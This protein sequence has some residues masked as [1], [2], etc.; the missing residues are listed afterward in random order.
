[1]GNILSVICSPRGKPATSITATENILSVRWK[2]KGMLMTSMFKRI[3]Q[4]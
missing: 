4:Y 3:F 2:I 1:M